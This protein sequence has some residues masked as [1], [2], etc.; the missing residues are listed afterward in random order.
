MDGK[1]IF[2][3]SIFIESRFLSFNDLIFY[4]WGFQKVSCSK[5]IIGQNLWQIV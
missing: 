3:L 1:I 2:A 5:A 4:G